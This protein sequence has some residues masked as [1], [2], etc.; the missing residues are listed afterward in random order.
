[1]YYTIQ[2]TRMDGLYKISLPSFDNI[3]GKGNTYDKA[4]IKLWEH[5]YNKLN[6]L[7][8]NDKK[9]PDSFKDIKSAKETGA[10]G[11]LKLTN[12]VSLKIEIYNLLTDFENIQQFKLLEK[13]GLLD[14]KHPSTIV[15]FEKAF[16]ILGYDLDFRLNSISKNQDLSN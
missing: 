11:V 4:F 2:I 8:Q 16:N 7:I 10:D 12:N 15:E 14:V 3:T 9:I 6:T 1:M 13:N 5:L